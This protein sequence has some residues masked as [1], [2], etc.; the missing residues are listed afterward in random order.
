[1]A[2]LLDRHQI[3]LQGGKQMATILR[4]IVVVMLVVL[5]FEE[6]FAVHD[7]IR[8]SSIPEESYSAL[9]KYVQI[10]NYSFRENVPVALDLKSGQIFLRLD[11]T[12]S[13]SHEMLAALCRGLNPNCA[14]LLLS[15]FNLTLDKFTD[16]PV[17]HQIELQTFLNANAINSRLEAVI[18][19]SMFHKS[20][21]A[22][23]LREQAGITGKEFRYE[24]V[25]DAIIS[26]DR[27]DLQCWWK[28]GNAI[29]LGAGKTIGNTPGQ[30]LFQWV[31]PGKTTKIELWYGST[32]KGV[33]LVRTQVGYLTRTALQNPILQE[34][35]AA[36]KISS[37]KK[38]T[39]ILF[40][41]LTDPIACQV[42]AT[43]AALPVQLVPR[44][45]HFGDG[46]VRVIGEGAWYSLDFGF[47][48]R[49][50]AKGGRVSDDGRSI[51]GSTYHV[52][53]S[54]DQLFFW[55]NLLPH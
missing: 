40:Y 1:M 34:K 35:L 8:G 25:K 19:A 38:N 30:Q 11:T 50:L 14:T 49:L 13:A 24:P 22:S 23:Q 9:D 47:D 55:D 52:I 39:V 28:V 18:D 37:D 53:E 15:A 27:D 4:V 21:V 43:D 17:H 29:Y 7:G 26:V 31:K 33:L 46:Q 42:A 36:A 16:D 41:D 51:V 3:R 12:G 44:S 32:G 45:N 48:V 5:L 6:G 20:T 10:T 54:E 2:E